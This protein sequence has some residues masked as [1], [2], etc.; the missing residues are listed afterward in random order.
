MDHTK[1]LVVSSCFVG[2]ITIRTTKAAMRLLLD[3]GAFDEGLPSRVMS[4]KI[5]DKVIFESKARLVGMTRSSRQD[6]LPKALFFMDGLETA[7]RSPST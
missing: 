6:L 5:K 3:L 2:K 1:L 4:F 7:S